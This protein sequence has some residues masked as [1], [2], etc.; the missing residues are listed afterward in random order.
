MKTL[1]LLLP[2]TLLTFAQEKK[3]KTGLYPEDWKYTFAQGV[4]G[5]KDYIEVP[6]IISKCTSAK[7]SS[8]A[9]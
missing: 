2:L 9:F 7:P 5:A 4:T 3:L 6:G 1:A 8:A